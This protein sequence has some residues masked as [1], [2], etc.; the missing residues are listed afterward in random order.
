MKSKILYG[1]PAVILL[2]AFYTLLSF[3]ISANS[4]NM[5][6]L[7]IAKDMAGGNLRLDG[8]SLS[9][10]S[11]IFSDIIW[12]VIAIKAFG[13]S[14]LL[15]HTLPSLMY[16]LMSICIFVLSSKKNYYGFVW[17]IP[18]IVFPTFFSGSVSFELNIHIGI[19]LFS[20]LSLLYFEHKKNDITIP[21]VVFMSIAGGLLIDSDKLY[22]YIFTIP[23]ILSSCVQVLL[24][25]ETKYLR[26]LLVGLL[27]V[28]FYKLY[29]EFSSYFF[30]YTVPGI[31]PPEIA[32]YTLFMKNLG[33]F[34]D[35]VQR[36]FGFG[37]LL[38]YGNCKLQASNLVFFI[39]FILLSLY[40]SIRFFTKSLLDGFLSFS[41]FIAV[42]AFLFSNAPTDYNSARF[43]YMSVVFCSVLL[44]RNVK[45]HKKAIPAIYVVAVLAGACNLHGFYKQASFNDKTNDEISM[46]LSEKGLKNGYA[47]FWEAAV[48]SAYDRQSIIP[49]DVSSSLTPMHWLSKKQDYDVKRN[50]FMS[51][52]PKKIDVAISQFGIPSATYDFRGVTILKWEDISLPPNGISFIKIP[53]TANTQVGV[54]KNGEITSTNKAGYLLY[55]PY[56]PLTKGHYKISIYGNG[57]MDGDHVEVVDN[58][59]GK[60]VFTKDLAFTDQGVF[61]DEFYLPD[62]SSSIELRVSTAGGHTLK[63]SGYSIHK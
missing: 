36:I 11:Y 17:L 51:S 6:S 57:G 7:L 8:W 55:G 10:Q 61:S 42:S 53:S 28:L 39:V 16:T 30:L 44:A 52:D 37:D 21:V 12:T 48:V 56:S 54:V 13:Y 33:F 47:P 5:S 59:A 3:A 1:I 35:G 14:P 34:W 63:V 27:S 26:L 38:N 43:F 60:I 32:N 45:I 20:C 15:A 4:D 58:T 50:F 40:C 25:K 2:T 29:Q 23:L 9:T 46:F 41:S 49:V 22:M 62:E 19:Y 31:K 18:V 24:K